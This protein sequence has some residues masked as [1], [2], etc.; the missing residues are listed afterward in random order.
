MRSR[1]IRTSAALAILELGLCV[2]GYLVYWIVARP[3]DLDFGSQYGA[4]YI[5]VH[6]GWSHLYDLQLLHEFE[7]ANHLDGL[8][9]F[10]HPPPV[11][12]LAVPFLVRPLRWA[13]LVLRPLLL[14]ALVPAALVRAPGR[15][16]A[17]AFSMLS[18][19]DFRLVRVALATVA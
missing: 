16:W 3:G 12:W 1:L 17:R 6:H 7:A 11:A 15:R 18:V 14:L 2:A 8:A 4:A 9:P 5:A 19:A 10:Q 13:A